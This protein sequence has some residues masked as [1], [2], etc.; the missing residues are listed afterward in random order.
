[1]DGGG[2]L[3][4]GFSVNSIG[5]APAADLEAQL[6]MIWLFGSNAIEL[7]QPMLLAVLR[8]GPLPLRRVRDG[9]TRGKASTWVS[10]WD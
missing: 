3:R 4:I 2:I 10:A 8:D 9:G 7:W 5:V 1:M 6:P